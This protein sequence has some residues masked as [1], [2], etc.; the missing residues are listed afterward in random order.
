LRTHFVIAALLIAAVSPPRAAS[1][2]TPQAQQ[3]IRV[4][5]QTEDSGQAEELAARKA[6]VKD[7][8]E[9]LTS[10][11]K[12]LTVVENEDSADVEV[13]VVER[14]VTIPKVVLGIGGS[15]TRPGQPPTAGG[16]AR[17]AELHVKVT[18][19][20]DGLSVKLKNKNKAADNPR[21]WKSAAEDLADQIGKWVLERREP[22]L[23]T[24]V[25]R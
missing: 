11:K 13:E 22:I 16:P 9:A 21:G 14:G 24:R 25:D 5:V 6:S 8:S 1:S 20:S 18:M 7:L 23:T 12:L 17:S 10:K 2:A 15:S 3:L 19:K 4:F